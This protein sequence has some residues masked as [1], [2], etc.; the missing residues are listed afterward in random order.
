MPTQT[1]SSL[2][3]QKLIPLQGE[4]RFSKPVHAAKVRIG[5]P[6][7][8]HGLFIA[9]PSSYVSCASFN[10]STQYDVTQCAV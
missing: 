1:P 5:P 9:K 8:N 3:C 2:P 4:S 6:G 10:G 7:T